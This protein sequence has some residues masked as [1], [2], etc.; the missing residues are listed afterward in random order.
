MKRFKLISAIACMLILT[1]VFSMFGTALSVPGDYDKSEKVT[2]KD[3][4]Y[5]LYNTVFGDKDYPLY[6]DGD[7]NGDGRIDSD[8]A[9]YMLYSSIFGTEDYPLPEMDQSGRIPIYF[10]DNGVVNSYELLPGDALPDGKD[11][12]NADFERF[13]FLGW[14]DASLTTKYE[15]VPDHVVTVY[16]KYDGYTS[17]SFDFGGIYDPNNRN[18]VERIKNP[19]GDGYVLKT[20]VINNTAAEYNGTYRGFAPST[21]DSNSN[22]GFKVQ[23]GHR[24]EVSFDYRYDEDAPSTASC[25]LTP[26]AVSSEGVHMDLKASNRTQLS[27][28]YSSTGGRALSN[29]GKWTECKFQVTVNSDFEYFYFRLLGSSRTD[30]YDFYVD[31]LVI[32]DVTADNSIK[33]STFGEIDSTDL[34]IGDT[35]PVLDDIHDTL[36]E[37]TFEFDGW[38]NKELTTKYTTVVDGVDTYYAKYKGYSAYTFESDGIFDPNGKY[39]ATSKGNAPWW[40]ELDPTGEDN[41]CLRVDLSNNSANTNVCL[42]AVEGAT[43]GYKLTPGNRYVLYYSYYLDTVEVSGFPSVSV[44]GSTAAGIGANGGKTDALTSDNLDSVGAWTEGAYVFTATEDTATSCYLIMLAQRVGT[45][46]TKIYY[47]NI[48]ICE[49]GSDEDIKIPTPAFNISAN[50]HGDVTEVATTYI[51]AELP[52]V[53]NYYGATFKGWYNEERTVP[54]LNVPGNNYDLYAVHDGDILNF[55]NGGVYDPN[56]KFGTGGISPHSIV[57]DPTNSKNTVVKATFNNNGNNTNFG[58]NASG[59][60]D[61]GYKLT[62][63]NTYEISFMYYLTGTSDVTVGIQFRGCKEEN[64]SIAGGKSDSCGNKTLSEMN[65]WT[66]VTVKFTY[67]GKNLEGEESPYLIMLAQHS[68]SKSGTCLYIDDIV[69]KESEPAKTYTKK[70]VKFSGWTMGYDR[71]HYIVIPT[72]NFSYLA[73]MQCEE[74]VTLIKNITTTSTDIKIVTEENWT[75][76]ENQFNIF[77]GDVKGHSRDNAKYKI[78][79]SG[80]T[81]DDYAYNLGVSSIYIDGGS[82]YALAMGISEVMK[83]LEA[84]KDGTDIGGKRVTGKYSEKID[85]YSTATYYRPT[86]LEDFDGDEIDT[87]RWNVVNGSGI[88]ARDYVDENG[89]VISAKDVVDDKGNVTQE[90]HGWQSVRSAEHTYLEDGKLVIEAAYSKEEKTFYGGMLRSHG[91]VEYRYGYYEVS[92]VTPNGKGIWTANWLTPNSSGDG[93]YRSEI[94]INESF[95]NAK[96]S[97]FNMHSWPR[98]TASNLGMGKY[99]LDQIGGASAKN[100]T[101]NVG[102]GYADGFH[103]FGYYWDENTAK[104]IVDGRVQFQYNYN[105]THYATDNLG[106]KL[107]ASQIRTN[108][109]DAF[110]EKVSIIVSMTVANP[111][112]GSNPILG[113]DYWNT[114]NKYIVDYVHIYQIDGQEIYFY[115]DETEAE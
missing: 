86:F 103:T 75:E 17:Y 38:Y 78:N 94:D 66:G 72:Y 101:L 49:F 89:N 1:M 59:Y 107:S 112:S 80:F 25:N 13:D 90:G 74:L 95:G 104:F 56:D 108:D 98:S 79:T 62:V 35:L 76:Q 16:A 102:N 111:S 31:N 20:L 71:P 68:S 82:T 84:A 54:Y 26:F 7:L 14:Y 8:D 88:A 2:A 70:S 21:Y 37:K 57:A 87:T 32:T 43:D 6:Y 51:G 22:T 36:T 60:S 96:D 28:N 65:T 50:D 85:S 105:D 115:D 109:Y 11:Y 92:C 12:I 113:A 69:I 40:R 39:S 73:R 5:L 93:F 52:A 29:K 58:L 15:T 81:N 106:N 67:T 9:V 41:I 10:N 4:I 83:E 3:A 19:F 30:A 46:Y 34:K 100:S 48:S 23:R 55:E 64:I 110:R 44:R 45:S 24:Y 61:E 63:G 33:L 42:Q 27:P 53:R 77:V 91:K 114:T 47:D 99:S 18:M 97:N